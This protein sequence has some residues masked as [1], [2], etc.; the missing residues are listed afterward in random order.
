MANSVNMNNIIPD[1]MIMTNI[2][3]WQTK[4]LSPINYG[5]PHLYT[6]SQFIKASPCLSVYLSSNI[7]LVY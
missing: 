4:A 1:N 6:L 2:V 5:M 7:V 3:L